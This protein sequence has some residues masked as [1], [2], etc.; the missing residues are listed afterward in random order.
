MTVVDP[1]GAGSDPELPTV[2]LALDPEAVRKEFMRG[3]PRLAGKLGL[4]RVKSIAVRRDKPGR[5]CVIEYDVRISSPD[6]TRLKAG[7]IGKVRTRR[8]GNESYRL[9]DAVWAAGFE[10]TSPDGI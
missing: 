4:V 5:R 8:F 10:A 9:L 7:L 3:L 2:A 6:G 1:F